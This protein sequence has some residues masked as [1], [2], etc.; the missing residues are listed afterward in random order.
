MAMVKDYMHGACRIMVYDDY[1]AG[2]TE[3]QRKEDL[4][5]VKAAARQA[6]LARVPKPEIEQPQNENSL[7]SLI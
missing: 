7:T 4:E 3:E 6:V 2:R 5:K 1:Y